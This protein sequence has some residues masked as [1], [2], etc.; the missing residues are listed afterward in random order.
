MLFCIPVHFLQP[1]AVLGLGRLRQE[2]GATLRGAAFVP[3]AGV[4]LDN[5]S[6]SLPAPTLIHHG[7]SDIWGPCDSDSARIPWWLLDL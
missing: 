5:I 3:I 6:V 2:D 1:E 4:S 7:L